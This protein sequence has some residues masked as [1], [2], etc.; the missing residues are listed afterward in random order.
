M[1]IRIHACPRIGV[2]YSGF[3]AFSCAH[4]AVA[5]LRAISCL[6][7]ALSF[8]ARAFPPLEGAPFATASF[9]SP[10]ASG[11]FFIPRL[12]YLPRSRESKSGKIPLDCLH[13]CMLFLHRGRQQGGEENG[14]SRD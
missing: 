3:F 7:L 13:R 2:H 4:R 5:A 1:A 8:S 9:A 6:R 10:T 14:G 12:V 11:F